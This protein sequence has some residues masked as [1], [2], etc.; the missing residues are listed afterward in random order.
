MEHHLQITTPSDRT[1]SRKVLFLSSFDYFRFRIETHLLF[2]A[3]LNPGQYE[4][5]HGIFLAMCGVAASTGVALLASAFFDYA[6]GVDGAVTLFALSVAA[7]STG[8]LEKLSRCLRS[9]GVPIA[10]LTVNFALTAAGV[11]ILTDLIPR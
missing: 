10:F 11:W 2:T 5:L 9:T 8:I 3:S 7:V 4:K 6:R 1:D